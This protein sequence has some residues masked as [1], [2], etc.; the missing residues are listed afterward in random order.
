M[1]SF[2]VIL[3][4]QDISSYVDNLGTIEEVQSTLFANNQLFAGQQDIVLDNTQNVFT[5]LAPGSLFKTP[6]FNAGCLVYR[7]EVLVFQGLVQ[8]LT[9]DPETGIATL[10]LVNAL[11]P[12][13][14]RV[15]DLVAANVEPAGACLAIFEQVGL[16]YFIDKHSFLTAD[17]GAKKA[18]ARIS[19]SFP[20]SAQVTALQA[21]Q[22]V[23]DVCSLDIVAM[24]QIIYARP[25]QAYPGHESNLRAEINTGNIRKFSADFYDRRSLANR[26]EV[27]WGTN[28]LHVVE[29]QLAQAHQSQAG[30]PSVITTTLACGAG[31]AVGILDQLSADYFGGLIL[32]R[33]KNVPRQCQVTI[34]PIFGSIAVGDCHPLTVVSE[35]LNR[36]PMRAITVR[37]SFTTDDIEVTFVSLS[38]SQQ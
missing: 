30:L 6:W 8:N 17:L 16:G 19:V 21:L 1:P 13:A 35:G 32:E 25:F 37:R 3:M 24:G 18:N 10:G 22:Q 27:N 14:D 33:H 9:L 23:A 7:D 38:G 11:A 29:D 26:V 34:D 15:V 31:S 28:Q 12:L 36:V 2:Q 20:A 4:G 5:P